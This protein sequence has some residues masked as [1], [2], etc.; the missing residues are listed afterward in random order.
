ML[1]LTFSVLQCVIRVHAAF[2]LVLSALRDHEWGILAAQ[3]AL[4]PGAHEVLGVPAT[5]DQLAVLILEAHSRERQPISD[6]VRDGLNAQ[7]LG[8]RSSGP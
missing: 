2:L 7:L 1:V 3:A 4:M 5:C 6:L 8:N